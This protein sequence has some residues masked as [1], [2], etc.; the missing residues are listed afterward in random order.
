[1]PVRYGPMVGSEYVHTFWTL[2]ENTTSSHHF[3]LI[4]LTGN[5][6]YAPLTLGSRMWQR[7]MCIYARVSVCVYACLHK[8]DRRLEKEKDREQC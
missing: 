8:R 5:S 6:P 7:P 4:N 3:H 1:M 2:V